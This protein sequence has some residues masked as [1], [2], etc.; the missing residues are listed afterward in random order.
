MATILLSNGLEC[1]VDDADY[2]WLS[3]SVWHAK[4]TPY[5]TYAMRHVKVNG[6][7]TSQQMHRVIVGAEKG[8][9]VDHEN[10]NGLDNQRHN[11]R[12]ATRTQNN[13]NAKAQ[14]GTSRFKGVCWDASRNQWMAYISCDGKRRYMGRYTDEVA[15]ARCYDRE[16][17]ALFGSFARL[18]FAEASP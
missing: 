16:A 7:R 1:T 4:T 12:V 6:K 5:H 10:R 14:G 9:D 2:D 15:A 11:I 13:A 3:Q 17:A 18:N 8:V